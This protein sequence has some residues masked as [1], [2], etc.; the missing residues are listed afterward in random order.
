MEPEA[1]P[2]D[3]QAQLT[4]QAAQNAAERDAAEVR[5]AHQRIS[6]ELDHLA[7]LRLS[8]RFASHVRA[9][10]RQLAQLVRSV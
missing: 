3:Y 8:P 10:R 1:V 5:A 9:M 4:R 7:A 2:P 6:D